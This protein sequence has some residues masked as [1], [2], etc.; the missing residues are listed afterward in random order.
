MFI[1]IIN[2]FQNGNPLKFNYYYYYITTPTS[3]IVAGDVI[4]YSGN[5]NYIA[6]GANN[7]INNTNDNSQVTSIMGNFL[8]GDVASK[9]GYDTSVFE[10]NGND[11]YWNFVW[12][13]W[14]SCYDTLITSQNVALTFTIHDRTYTFYSSDFVTPNSL[15]K[16][17]CTTFLIVGFFFLMYQQIVDFIHELEEGD[18]MVLHDT[19]A[20]CY[21]F[22][23]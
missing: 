18:L 7:N 22:D 8:S 19:D 1:K 17:F 2:L 13:F 12:G 15:L 14:Q 23:L 9:M 5:S 4:N 6:P 10:E 11:K 3:A 16:N 20:D 21:F